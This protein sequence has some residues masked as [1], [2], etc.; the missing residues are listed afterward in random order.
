MI[1]S[2]TAFD[3]SELQDENGR[4]VLEIRSVNSRYLDVNLRLP[5]DLRSAE[6]K[7]RETIAKYLSR[8]KVD[9]SLKFEPTVSAESVNIDEQLAKAVIEGCRKINSISGADRDIDA[10]QILKWPGVLQAEDKDLNKLIAAVVILLEQSLKKLI[11]A[12]EREGES[13][14]KIIR[15]R[16]QGIA[17]IV[18][19]VKLRV[20]EVIKAVREK[21]VTK[22]NDLK[23]D[24]EENNPRL[25]QELVLQAQ[26]LDVDEELDRLETHL[27]EIDL[28]LKK[29]E[30]IGRKLD[31]LMQE[32]NREANTLG[33]K[34]ADSET[35]KASVD[36]KVLIEQM[37]E[38]IQ[39]IE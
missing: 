37:R 4:F 27:K 18:A 35:T 20:P 19:G 17:E 14:E 33:S 23:L 22:I 13:L 15:T 38:Q 29:S 26:K 28:V 31:F 34:S 3:R 25:E 5:E 12:R 32:L 36:M 11:E 21:V 8:G 6:T 10:M 39:N 1:R 16:M 2:M 9:C 30:P 24:L 7:I